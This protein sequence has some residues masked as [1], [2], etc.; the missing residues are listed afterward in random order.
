MGAVPQAVGLGDGDAVAGA[1]FDG[2]GAGVQSGA[3]I[4]GHLDVAEFDGGG[5]AVDGD[6]GGA[7][8]G[9]DVVGVAAQA[10]GGLVGLVE[11]GAGGGAV[12]GSRV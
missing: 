6:V 2:Q 11:V 5:D 7:E 8:S 12:V 1:A 9:P 3:E 10:A 4:D